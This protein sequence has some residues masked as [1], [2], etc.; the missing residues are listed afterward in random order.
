[1]D[2]K[3]SWDE[4]TADVGIGRQQLSCSRSLPP[5]ILPQVEETQGAN[6]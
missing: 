6:F 5:A 4:E 1:M 3:E 2:R